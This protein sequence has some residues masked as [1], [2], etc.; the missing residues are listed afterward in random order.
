MTLAIRLL[1]FR[2]NR[3]IDALGPLLHVELVRYESML[4][5]IGRVDQADDQ[6]HDDEHGDRIVLCANGDRVDRVDDGQVSVERHEDESVDACVGRYVGH[7]LVELAHDVTERPIGHRVTIGSEWNAEDD[8]EEIGDGQTD[9]EDVGGA[10]HLSVEDDDDDDEQVSDESEDGD[11]AE[12]EWHEH[13]D[14]RLE[15]DL[16]GVKVAVRG[17]IQG[18]CQLVIGGCA[19][20]DDGRHSNLLL[21]RVGQE[22][23]MRVVQSR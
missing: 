12:Q 5:P 14:E 15:A 16:I 8:E 20:V 23:M 9:D 10:A 17:I 18:G 4:E 6:P 21:L 13:G 22:M 3:E 19:R 1:Q 7:V 2:I 11:A